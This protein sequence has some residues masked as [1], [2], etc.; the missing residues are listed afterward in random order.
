M[1]KK[2]INGFFVSTASTLNKISGVFFFS[3]FISEKIHYI[4]LPLVS[5]AFKILSFIFYMIGYGLW[6]ATSYFYPN[7]ITKKEEWYNFAQFKEQCLLAA[8]LGIVATA[9][10]LAGFFVPIL[11]IPAAW[12][13]LASN[14]M[15]ASAE[16]H[17]LKNPPICD[18]NYSHTYQKAYVP[19]VLKM[20]FIS[21]ITALSITASFLFPPVTIPVLIISTLMTLGLGFSAFE[22]WLDYTFGDHKP[23]LMA[24]TSYNQMHSFLGP[25]VVVKETFLP[26]PYHTKNLLK[27][28]QKTTE[29]F[30]SDLPS[31]LII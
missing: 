5:S 8:T 22:N 4:P 3:G 6:F 15:W 10:S 31:V 27:S 23:V 30:Y 25:S 7:H 17:K 12:V 19:Y 11:L 20:A 29:P 13:F 2:N 21:C 16:Y 26:A 14:F 18:T 24:Q 9:L 28:F 1:Y